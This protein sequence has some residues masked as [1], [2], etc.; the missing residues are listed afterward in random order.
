MQLIPVGLLALAAL[1]IAQPMRDAANIP[2][3]QAISMDK[4]AIDMAKDNHP[5]MVLADTEERNAMTN[6]PMAMNAQEQKQKRH[7]LRATS[8]AP[9]VATPTSSAAVGASAT[10]TPPASYGDYGAYSDYGEYAS[11]GDYAPE[12]G[13]DVD[14]TE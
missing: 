7:D 2:Q 14:G 3:T 6:H 12:V 1:A 10:P 8:S 4:N 5:M 11:Y 9:V 13:N